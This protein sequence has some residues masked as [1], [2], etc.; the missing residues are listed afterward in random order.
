[1]ELIPHCGLVV[2]KQI[3]IGGCIGQ[4]GIDLL[5]MEAATLAFCDA[6][7]EEVNGGLTIGESFEEWVPL[8]VL[9]LD[10]LG[11]LVL[12]RFDGRT[13]HRDQIFGIGVVVVV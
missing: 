2:G 7:T 13:D 8:C 1:M 3:G 6:K 11:E 12:L 4:V 9:P 10:S 5:G